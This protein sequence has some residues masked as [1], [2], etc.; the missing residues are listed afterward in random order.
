MDK[1]LQKKYREL[2]REYIGHLCAT[3]DQIEYLIKQFSDED[4]VIGIHNTGISYENIFKVGLY[5]QTDGM[6]NSEDL[7]NT[8][9]YSNLL[10]V[11]AMYPNGD[12]KKRGKTAIILKIPNEVFTHE[13]GIFEQLQ[14]GCYVIPTQFIVG[15]FMDGDIIENP[16]YQKGYE[17]PDAIVCQDPDYCLY[18]SN[19]SIQVEVFRKE[20]KRYRNSLKSRITRFL[21]KIKSGKDLKKLPPTEEIEESKSGSEEYREALRS[22]YTVS[23]DYLN[24]HGGE[25]NPNKERKSDND[26]L[27]R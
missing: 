8:V 14:D 21:E 20:Q 10:P 9:N 11:L 18:D 24:V 16:N 15:A 19:K 23:E 22:E 1:K 25:D 7:T 17:N 12:G 5:N 4:C 26:I 27:S 6:E 3:D 13:Q 2:T